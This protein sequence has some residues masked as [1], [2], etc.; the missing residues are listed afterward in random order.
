[1]YAGHQVECAESIELMD[2]PAHP[3]TKLLLSAVPNPAAGLTTGGE[4][5]RGE[6]PSLIDPPPGCPFAPRCPRVLPACRESMPEISHLT[7]DHWVRCHLYP[8]Q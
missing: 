6:I 8:V 1:M 7:S 2:Q 3:Y 5:A 4:E